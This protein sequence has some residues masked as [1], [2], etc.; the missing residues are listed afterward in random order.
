MYEI[1]GQPL[2][3]CPES[4]RWLNR[5]AMGVDGSGRSAYEPNRSFELSWS[6]M[7]PAAFSQLCGF[8]E[9]VANT[10]T[11]SVV[12]PDRCADLWTGVLYTAKL[13]E[14]TT[15]GYWNRYHLGVRLRIRDIRT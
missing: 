9:A 10:G 3:L 2:I 15:R 12:L 14:P 1:N 7:E 11:V 8:Y 4:S 6:I 13:D 5:G